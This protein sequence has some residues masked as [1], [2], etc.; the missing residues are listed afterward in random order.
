MTHTD[1]HS[2]LVYLIIKRRFLVPII[3]INTV[4]MVYSYNKILL[5]NKTQ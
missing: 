3:R 4:T 1:I 2:S 5:S